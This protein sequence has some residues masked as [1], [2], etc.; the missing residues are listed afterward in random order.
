MLA[1]R[2]AQHTPCAAPGALRTVL[3]RHVHRGITAATFRNELRIVD[4]LPQR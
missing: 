4:R 1:K 2:G 3:S